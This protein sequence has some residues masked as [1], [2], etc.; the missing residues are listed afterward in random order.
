MSARLLTT[1]AC[2]SFRSRCARLPVPTR[3]MRRPPRSQR[4]ACA[5]G[6]R[7][8]AHAAI[9]NFCRLRFCCKRPCWGTAATATC[10]AA[11]SGR[12]AH[13]RLD[14]VVRGVLLERV[15][16]EAQAAAALL[17]D[18]AAHVG[19]HDDERVL[20]VHSAALRVGQAAVLQDLQHLR[21]RRAALAPPPSLSP[22]TPPTQAQTVSGVTVI[23]VHAQKCT[24]YQSCPELITPRAHA[25]G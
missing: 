12:A 4:R 18:R 20:E 7:P 25:T 22:T 23:Q 11:L 21:A 17:D 3:G 6:V 1:Q 15:Q 5:A 2:K 10:T 8:C 9:R 16:L 24:T 13:Q 14:A 19:R